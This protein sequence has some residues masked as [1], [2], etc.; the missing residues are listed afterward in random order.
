MNEN[1]RA[2][3]RRE[4]LQDAVREAV[5]GLEPMELPP[6]QPTE[7]GDRSLVLCIGDFHFGSVWVVNGLYGECINR[8]DPDVFARRMAI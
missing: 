5:S 6:V 8:Y 4:A 1:Y 7:S 3:A 2:E